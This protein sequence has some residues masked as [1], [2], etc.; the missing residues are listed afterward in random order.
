MTAVILAAG[1]GNRYGGL[2]QVDPLG[3]SGEF[4]IDYSVY[5]AIR[6]GFD[7]VVFIIKRENYDLFRETISKR[8]EG[9]I[10]IGYAF[11]DPDDL[12]EGCTFPEGRKKPLGTTHA[13]YCCRNVVKD[14]FAVFNADD[15]YG[16]EA[17]SIVAEYLRGSDGKHFCMPGYVVRNTLSEFGSVS[18]G[19]CRTENGKLKNIV[20]RKEILPD[21]IHAKY[22]D[23]DE[24]VVIPGDTPVSMNFWGF[25]PDVFRFAEARL[26]SFFTDPAKDLLTGESYLTELVDDIVRSEA[27]SLD[28]LHTDSVW[29]GVTYREDRPAFCAFLKEQIK[30]GKYPENLWNVAQIP[31]GV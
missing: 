13:L 8:I 26:K 12:P 9:K 28:V 10:G 20:E 2:K 24:W 23:G 29:K 25:S 30:A 31:A 6:A 14:H 7:N 15:F 11:Q 21:G 5:D 3:P 16:S 4:I 17:F 22:K 18:R 27:Y 19:V 1:M